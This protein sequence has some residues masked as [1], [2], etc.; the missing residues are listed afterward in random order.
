MIHIFSTLFILNEKYL[1]NQFSSLKYQFS[2]LVMYYTLRKILHSKLIF[3]FQPSLPF[4]SLFL[5]TRWW[6]FKFS[7]YSV[8]VVF[9]LDFLRIILPKTPPVQGLTWE[10]LTSIIFAFWPFFARAIRK[11]RK[12]VLYGRKWWFSLMILTMSFWNWTLLFFT[13][14]TEFFF[15]L[16][17]P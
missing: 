7:I 17:L 3:L 11:R 4:T 10:T 14:Y 1:S 6:S 9:H 2:Y 13:Y 5:L 16:L 8:S 12:L 15:L